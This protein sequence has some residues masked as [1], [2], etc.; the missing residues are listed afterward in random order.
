MYGENNMET[1]KALHIRWQKYWSFSFSISPSSEH[2]GLISFRTDGLI[3]LQLKGLSRVF[4]NTR[5][6]KNQFFDTQLSL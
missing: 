6:Q 2:S 1:Y 5:V 3:S 4:S